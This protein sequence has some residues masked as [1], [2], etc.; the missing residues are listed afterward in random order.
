MLEPRSLNPHGQIVRSCL[1]QNTGK[2]I[3]TLPSIMDLRKEWRM[4][5]DWEREQEVTEARKWL[6]PTNKDRQKVKIMVVREN[7][8]LTH[9]FQV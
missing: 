1:K 3:K 7:H 6:S 5:Q 9:F 2:K 4:L 8:E